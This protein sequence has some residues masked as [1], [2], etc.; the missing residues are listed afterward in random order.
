MKELLVEVGDVLES[1]HSK[2]K[3]RLA[4]VIYIGDDHVTLETVRNADGATVNTVGHTSDVSI[5]RLGKDYKLHEDASPAR[6][7]VLN[8]VDITDY[9]STDYLST[10]GLDYVEPET[11][12]DDEPLTE[13][14]IHVLASALAEVGYHYVPDLQTMLDTIDEAVGDDWDEYLDPR[15]AVELTIRYITEF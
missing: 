7:Y 5:K 10:D 1:R 4:K 8:N 12:E 14:E 3:G 9:L 15:E 6:T 11:E 2:R 13:D